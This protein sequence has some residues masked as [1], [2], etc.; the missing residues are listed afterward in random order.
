M[1]THGEAEVERRFSALDGGM[2]DAVGRDVDVYSLLDAPSI[3]EAARLV[4]QHRAGNCQEQAALAFDMLARAGQRPLE[5]MSIREQDHV[6]VVVGRLS[7]TPS[8]HD[9]W[10]KDTVICDAWAKRAYF[11]YALEDEMQT[12]RSVTNGEV[13]MVQKFRLGPGAIW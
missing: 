3:K 5:L 13:R 1:Q 8:T 4:G 7:G 9:A 6:V 2:L 10:N 11:V 12:I